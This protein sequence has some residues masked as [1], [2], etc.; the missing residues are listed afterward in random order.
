[1]ID[2][3]GGFACVLVLLT[4]SMRNMVMLRFVAILSNLAFISYAFM[5]DLMPVL[6]LHTI[7]LPINLHALWTIHAPKSDRGFVVSSKRTMHE[8]SRRRA[9]SKR[10]TARDAG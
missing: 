9:T 2:L 6:A 5:A 10:V 8:I 1:M 4:F 7:L 3:V